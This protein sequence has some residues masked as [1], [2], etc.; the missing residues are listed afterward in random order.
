M[1][2]H[3][4]HG[5]L[6]RVRALPVAVPRLEH[7]QA[8]VSQDPHHG[9]ARP[10]VRQGSLPARGRQGEGARGG[11]HRRHRGPRGPRVRLWPDH[12]LHQ[13]AVRAPARRYRSGGRGH[14]PRRPVVLHNLRRLRRAV[15]RGHRARRPHPGHAPLSGPDRVRLPVRGWRDAAQSREQGQPVGHEQL[16]PDRLD[17]RTVLRRPC[18]RRD[19]P[20]RR[21]V[22]VLGRLRRWP[23]GPLQ[24]GL[25][26]V[27]RA[28]PHCRRRVRRPG[29]AGV[30]LG[31][32]RPSP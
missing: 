5:H 20:R 10:L 21:R 4:R 12:G 6:H 14:R 19:H 22:P 28:A 23:R 9:P 32:P 24:K 30:L 15:P 27:R 2:R 17:G 7:R 16:L 18:R 29:F 26:R 13:G 3:A 8:V 25:P 1:V 11:L 31:G